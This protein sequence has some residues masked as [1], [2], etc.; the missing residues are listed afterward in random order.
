MHLIV[1]EAGQRLLAIPARVE[2]PHTD[3]PDRNMV[4]GGVN[5]VFVVQYVKVV[6]SLPII[7]AWHMQ[8]PISNPSLV[9]RSMLLQKLLDLLIVLANV[10]RIPAVTPQN[11]FRKRR[12]LTLDSCV[13]TAHNTLSKILKAM[14]EMALHLRRDVLAGLE[15]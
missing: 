10:L 5:E 4:L 3:E 13:S 12:M 11:S 14:R 2:L 1:L 7:N 8:S 6:S 15:T 9:I